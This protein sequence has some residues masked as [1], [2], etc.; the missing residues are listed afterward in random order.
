MKR[1][2]II[3]SNIEIGNRNI[4]TDLVKLFLEKL[5]IRCPYGSSKII[6]CINKDFKK[7]ILYEKRCHLSGIVFWAAKEGHFKL[8]EFLKSWIINDYDWNWMFA[9]AAQGEHEN[10]CYFAKTYGADDYNFMLEMAAKGGSTKL[11]KIVSLELF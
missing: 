5:K 10:I 7:I 2:L 3:S 9:G 8:C 6:R 11:C 1:K 4:P